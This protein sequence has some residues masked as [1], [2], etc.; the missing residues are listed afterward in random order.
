MQLTGCFP[1]SCVPGLE[2]DLVRE[3]EP[4]TLDTK[5]ET[6]VVDFVYR[7]RIYR[8]IPGSPIVNMF[9]SQYTDTVINRPPT[10]TP[11][12]IFQTHENLVALRLCPD[13]LHGTL[14][15]IH[16]EL[17]KGPSYA[18]IHSLRRLAARECGI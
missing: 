2:I 1:K 11:A 12:Q 18:Y 13:R 15:E 16:V 7:V 4:I 6:L 10:R 3:P 9:I 8:L 5:H 17:D 14:L